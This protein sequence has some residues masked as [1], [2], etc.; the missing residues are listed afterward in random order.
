MNKG[1]TNISHSALYMSCSIIWRR[2]AHTTLN[3]TS[4][5]PFNQEIH[6][7]KCLYIHHVYHCSM[8]FV[9]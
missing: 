2:S 8:L 7:R 5:L 4:P 9:S 6:D 3:A 1:S